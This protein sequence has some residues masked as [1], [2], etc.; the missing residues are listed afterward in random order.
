MNDDLLND[1]NMKI[2]TKGNSVTQS[3][4]DD[5]HQLKNSIYSQRNPTNSSIW[6][7]ATIA[8]SPEY[9]AGSLG[10]NTFQNYLEVSNGWIY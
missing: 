4:D 9:M 1:L 8:I 7:M 5:N 6:N 3:A 10:G 2:E